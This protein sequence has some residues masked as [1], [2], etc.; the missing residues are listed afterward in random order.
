MAMSILINIWAF[1]RKT[2]S[3]TS[4]VP[5]VLYLFINLHLIRKRSFED[6][7]KLM[8]Q[9]VGSYWAFEVTTLQVHYQNWY[10]MKPR[11]TFKAAFDLYVSVHLMT[12]NIR[13]KS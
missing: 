6:A 7:W 11:F 8:G 10:S 12:I 5:I 13:T 3:V 1:N 4:P 2:D 9:N